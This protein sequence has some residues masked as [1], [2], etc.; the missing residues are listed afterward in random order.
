MELLYKLL[1]ITNIE[2]IIAPLPEVIGIS[3][4]MPRHSLLQRLEGIGERALLGVPTQAKIGLEWATVGVGL[5]D[6][7]VNVLRHHDVAV[8]AKAEVAADAF[9]SVLEHSTARVVDKEG[10]AMITTKRYEMTLPG[11]LI[12]LEAPRHEISVALPTA[13]LKPK[14]DLNGPPPF[15]NGIERGS[16]GGPTQAKI[17][18]EWATQPPSFFSAFLNAAS[19]PPRPSNACL[20]WS[21]RARRSPVQS[22]PA[23]IAAPRDSPAHYDS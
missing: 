6:E 18:L 21:E 5:A 3:D 12:T 7:D 1:V 11:V 10:S 19:V 15:Q 9:E 17:G 14:P 2:I 22:L 16:L 8:D 4:Q 20:S 23:E 13:P